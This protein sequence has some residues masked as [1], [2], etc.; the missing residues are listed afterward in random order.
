MTRSVALAL[1]TTFMIGG[2][3][4]NRAEATVLGP[5]TIAP[6]SRVDESML[7]AK[8]VCGESR[9]DWQPWNVFHP[10]HD[11]ARG[12]REPRTPGCFRERRRGGWREVC[13]N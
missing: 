3:L 5:A 4:V 1:L 2:A 9:C 10:G 6:E 11:F 7:Q 13:P 8:W 12:W